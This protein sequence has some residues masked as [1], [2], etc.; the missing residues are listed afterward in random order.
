MEDGYFDSYGRIQTIILCTESFSKDECI[1]LQTILLRL[2]I[3][4]TLKIRNKA[5]DRYRIRISKKSIPLLR[6]LVLPYMHND[7][8]YK[9]YG[10]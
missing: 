5:N 8:M 10:Q 4:S 7:F 6:E 3:K 1:F 2:G 9:L